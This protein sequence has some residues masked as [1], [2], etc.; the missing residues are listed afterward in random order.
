MV[1]ILI[2][3]ALL[4]GIIYFD[5]KSNRVQGKLYY[6][7]CCLLMSLIFGLRYRVG[8][9]TLNYIYKYDNIPPLSQLSVFDFFL[10]QVEPGFALLMSF[11]KQFTDDFYCV[12]LVVS[13]FVNA[14]WFWYIYINV[15]KK[16]IGAL[17]YFILHSFYFNTEI[18]REAMAVSF[19]LIACNK[20]QKKGL[21]AYYLWMIPAISF[22]YSALFM[23]IIPYLLKK[24]RSKGYVI[25][26]MLLGLLITNFA[27]IFF[28]LFGGYL[29]LKIENTADY[30]FTIWGKLSIFI[31]YVLYAYV[32]LVIY[33]RSVMTDKNDIFLKYLYVSIIIGTLA[34]GRYSVLMRLFNYMFPFL[35]VVLVK[36][37]FVPFRSRRIIFSKSIL[38][39]IL[40]AFYIGYY[41]GDMS[42]HVSGARFYNLWYPYYSIFDEK[43]D[44]TR[45]VMV[46]EHF[47]VD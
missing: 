28:S 37:L 12:Q 3:L 26:F 18:M 36:V 24:V 43:K 30:T 10:F 7:F 31:K 19:F 8:G 29:A 32:L 25:L 34:L 33:K 16:F 21:R 13:L 27:S 42:R 41:F 47:N 38:L 46:Q 45:E 11:F 20:L 1:Y 35:L 6:C 22:H 39:F 9:D 14:V 5:K 23:L 2:I 40:C 15:D 4:I 17:L 44:Y